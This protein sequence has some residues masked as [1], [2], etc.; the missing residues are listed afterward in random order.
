MTE[1]RIIISVHKSRE[2]LLDILTTRGYDTEEYKGFSISEIHSLVQHNQLDML[3]ANNETN[4]KVYIKYH[5]LD[6]TIRPANIHEMVESLFT[7][8]HI[9]SPNDD[10]IIVV[11]DEP[12][13][14]LQ[15]LLRTY[16]AHDG[17]FIS[18]INIDRLQFNILKHSLVPKH[19][20]ISPEATEKIKEQYNIV[21]DANLPSISRF[22]PV[23]LVLGIRPG[24]IFEIE[25][26]SKTAISTKFYRIC[27]Q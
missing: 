18:L 27:S 12:N 7:V 26:S 10:L 24:Q 5:N 15:K 21:T 17:I 16:Y 2:I 11:K 14:T 25:R 13:D 1:N 4:K 20:L 19:T 22:D 6:K 8:E 23:S 9:L 3:V